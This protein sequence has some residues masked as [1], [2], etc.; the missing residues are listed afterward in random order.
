[1]DAGDSEVGGVQPAGGHG[2]HPGNL[3]IALARGTGVSS[4]DSGSSS[5]SGA[6]VYLV[7][8]NQCWNTTAPNGSAV[9]RAVARVTDAATAAS[10]SGGGI[11][12]RRRAHEDWWREFWA[13]SFVA[14]SGEAATRI[15]A[16]YYVNMYRYASACRYGVH[17]LTAAFGPGGIACKTSSFEPFIYKCDLFTKTGSGQT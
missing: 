17:D 14:I 5:G 7:S 13:E 15:E 9:E 3:A 10:A 11:S 1:V 6:A 2:C 12:T 16:M 8:S 4:S